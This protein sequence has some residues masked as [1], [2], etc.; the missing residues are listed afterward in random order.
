MLGASLEGDFSA[1]LEGYTGSRLE[2]V[3][4][5]RASQG[6]CWN[7][8]SLP[9]VSY[10]FLSSP[11]RLVYLAKSIWARITRAGNILATICG[12]R[13]LSG[14]RTGRKSGSQLR[15]KFGCQKK[16]W[17]GRKRGSNIGNQPR[18]KSG[19]TNWNGRRHGSRS[20]Y[21]AGRKSGCLAGRRSGNPLSSPNGSPHPT[22]ITIIIITMRAGIG[23]ART[24]PP[25]MLAKWYGN[26][27]IA[28]PQRQSQRN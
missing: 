3:L 17:S 7:V 4:D 20:G 11:S 23:I 27:T 24:A 19:T 9:T 1:C 6:K 25:K 22:T 13:R 8:Y 16:N 15:N 5:T 21:P 12:R 28:M 2:A 14:S 26:G 18:N 10:P